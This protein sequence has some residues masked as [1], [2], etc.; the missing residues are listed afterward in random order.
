MFLHV[1]CVRLQAYDRNANFG[2]DL[3]ESVVDM[4]LP[5]P[6]TYRDINTDS[7]VFVDLCK[8]GH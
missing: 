5:D 2:A 3:V 1:L 7:Q 4:V 6:M 8:I